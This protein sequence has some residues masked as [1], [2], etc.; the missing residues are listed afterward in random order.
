M[1]KPGDFDFYCEKALTGKTPIKKVYESPKVL[2][3]YHTQPSYNT[4]IVIIP[5]EHI[6]DLRFADAAILAEILAV[7]QKI[8]KQMAVDVDGTRVITNVGKFQDT[9]HL[10]FHVVSDG[11]YLDVRVD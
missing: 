11:G 7:G 10:H 8:V 2:A 3:F 9:P 6:H 4:H 5:K 1:A